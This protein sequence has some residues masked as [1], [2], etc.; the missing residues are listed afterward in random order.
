VGEG[1]SGRL[2]RRLREENGMGS[3]R[4]VPNVCSKP[5]ALIEAISKQILDAHATCKV[6]GAK[7]NTLSSEDICYY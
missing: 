6:D 2:Q 3:Q 7:T 1:G 5:K 4:W